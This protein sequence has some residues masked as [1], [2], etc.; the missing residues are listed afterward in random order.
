MAKAVDNTVL[1]AALDKIATAT[2]ASLCSGQPANFAGIAAVALADVT[3][4]SGDFTKA[5][6]DTSGRKVTVA[7]QSGVTVDATGTGTHIAL[8]DG[9]TLLYVTT[10]SST[11]VTSGGTVDLGAWDVEIADPS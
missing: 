9:T 10:C 3:I 5:D 8:D 6:G 4:D 2:R 11:A 1:D 7:A